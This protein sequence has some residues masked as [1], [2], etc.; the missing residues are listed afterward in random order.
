[1]THW[2]MTSPSALGGNERLTGSRGLLDAP[3]PDSLDPLCAQLDGAGFGNPFRDKVSLAFFCLFVSSVAV[4]LG[5]FVYMIRFL[6][7]A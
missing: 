2:R 1:M 6:W 4:F 3:Q 5:L 7:T